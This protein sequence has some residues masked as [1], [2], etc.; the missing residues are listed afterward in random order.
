MKGPSNFAVVSGARCSCRRGCPGTGT[1][2][3]QA[4][5]QSPRD[6]A[7]RSSPSASAPFPSLDVPQTPP[8]S[9]GCWRPTHSPAAAFDPGQKPSWGVSENGAGN[10]HCL[11]GELFMRNNQAKPSSCRGRT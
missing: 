7:A 11:S 6:E 2:R 9:R 4:V 3:G 10:S 1:M 8:M 5:L